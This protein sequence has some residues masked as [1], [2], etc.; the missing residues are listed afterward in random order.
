[1]LACGSDGTE[2]ADALVV[3]GDS[4]AVEETDFAEQ[5]SA[6]ADGHDDVSD[7]C[8]SANP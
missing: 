7:G 5:K 1:M 2:V 6:G 4:Q 3:C 8:L